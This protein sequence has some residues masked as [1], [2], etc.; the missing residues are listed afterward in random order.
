MLSAEKNENVSW[1][2]HL[3]LPFSRI[4][5]LLFLVATLYN[6]YNKT[7]FAT[8]TRILDFNGCRCKR[9]KGGKTV[10]VRQIFSLV[11]FFFRRVTPKCLAPTFRVVE[12]ASLLF[13]FTRWW[14]SV[15]PPSPVF[16]SYIYKYIFSRFFFARVV[17]VC[18]LFSL[19]PCTIFVP[20]CSTQFCWPRCR[21]VLYSSFLLIAP[22]HPSFFVPLCG[23]VR[24]I[25]IY[26]L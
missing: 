3:E 4:Y 14:R 20:F 13:F 24:L 16:F 19:P 17:C 9:S 11:L 22:F 23:R 21:F 7:L 1:R 8:T 12:L 5:S 26:I 18:G 15:T 25:Y 2:R 10:H 6:E